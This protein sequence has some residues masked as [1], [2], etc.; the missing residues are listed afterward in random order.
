M[1]RKKKADLKAVEIPTTMEKE[2]AAAVANVASVPNA[3]DAKIPLTK[4]VEEAPK[5]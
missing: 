1:G 2:Q 5:A 3:A 4:T